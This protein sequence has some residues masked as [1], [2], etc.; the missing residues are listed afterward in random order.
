MWRYLR[1]S[2]VPLFSAFREGNGAENFAAPSQVRYSVKP[3]RALSE[4]QAPAVTISRNFERKG[5]SFAQHGSEDSMLP[6]SAELPSDRK[7]VH[8]STRSQLLRG[9]A[10]DCAPQIA[11]ALIIARNARRGIP[12]APGPGG[13]DEW[14][15]MP[16]IASARRGKQPEDL[17]RCRESS[18]DIGLYGALQLGS[19]QKVD[20]NVGVVNDGAAVKP[21]VGRRCQARA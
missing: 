6:R 21:P 3:G 14:W 15:G 17:P 5:R 7:A 18:A 2:H 8:R 13:V 16:S 12:A 1:S 4:H 11:P 10:R 9:L 19:T 20:A